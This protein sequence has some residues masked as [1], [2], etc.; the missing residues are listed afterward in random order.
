MEIS[1]LATFF[2]GILSFLSPCVLPLLPL[3]MSYLAGDNKTVDEDGK[4]RYK[5]GKVFITTLFF[6]LGIC[7]TF[8]LLAV[9]VD[10]IKDYIEAYS[11][12][13]SIISGTLLIIFGLHNV[14]LIHIDV[15]DRELKLKLNL[16]LDKMNFIKAFLLGFVFSLGW[17][18]CI[19]PMLASAIMMAATNSQGYLYIV[20]YGLGLVIPFLITGLLTSTILN[21]FNDKKGLMKWVLRIA[22]IIIICFGIYMIY[23]GSSKIVKTKTAQEGSNEK[24]D[25]QAYLYNCE[26]VDQNG[27]KV[28]LSDYKGKYIFLNFSTTWCTYCNEERPDYIKFND[29]DEVECLYVMSPSQEYSPNAIENHIKENDIKLTTI[30]DNEDVL[31]YYCRIESFPTI[32]VVSPDG[33]FLT[34]FKGALSLE[35]FNSLLEYCK[36]L[37]S[38]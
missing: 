22:G 21:F 20:V 35:G 24:S 26:F 18:P 10:Y 32:Y 25:I 3:Y 4:V 38:E 6:V 1:L 5:T 33:E 12:I 29:N 37:E 36:G 34:Y 28:K 19:G 9:S 2:E 30:I 23:D 27:N 16:H 13:I 7:L 8:G 15:L 17:S 11:E 31:F 14:G